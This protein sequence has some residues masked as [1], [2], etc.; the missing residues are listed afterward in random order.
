MASIFITL[1]RV[2][3][4]DSM[5]AA[6]PSD[7]D[8]E[9]TTQP[10]SETDSD[11]DAAATRSVPSLDVVFD[12]LQNRRRRL[13]LEALAERDGATTL[14]ELAEHIAGIE[15][16]KPPEALDSQERK[17]VYVGLYQSHLPKMDDAGA[18]RFDGD[19]GSVERGPHIEEFRQYLDGNAAD[20]ALYTY[21]FGVAAASGLGLAVALFASG[22]VA[23]VSIALLVVLVGVAGARVTL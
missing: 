12:V 5:V 3:R 20:D 21:Y 13:V 1:G 17:R 15:N 10:R 6:A 8:A 22:M 11:G 14:G 9:G 7:R 16:D 19:R 23:A 4:E 2:S 18:I